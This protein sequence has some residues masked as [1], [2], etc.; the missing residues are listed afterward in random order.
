MD[1]DAF[2]SALRA[3]GFTEL[4]LVTRDAGELGTHTHPFEAKALILAG[5]IHICAD[6]AEPVRRPGDTFTWPPT[7]RTPS[8]AA[9]KVCS[10]WWRGA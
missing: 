6:G 1:R 9:R 10:T 4:V 5:E 3:E 2:V 7:H 8:A